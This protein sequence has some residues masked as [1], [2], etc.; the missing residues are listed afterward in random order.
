MEDSHS[1]NQCHEQITAAGRTPWAIRLAFFSGIPFGIFLSLAAAPIYGP[2]L[3]AWILTLG[4]SVVFTAAFCILATDG[5]G[6][7]AAGY[8]AGVASSA[9]FSSAISQMASGG[10]DLRI[11]Y[12]PLS[13]LS[14]FGI[15]FIPA[16]LTAS[17][18]GLLKW[19]DQRALERLVEES[20]PD[21]PTT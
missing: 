5:C 9:F 7:V 12:A 11:L 19:E 16:A 21:E 3:L 4:G 15:V 2:I 1:N 14:L 10:F 8:A 20:R 18:C 17:L 6:W 13:M